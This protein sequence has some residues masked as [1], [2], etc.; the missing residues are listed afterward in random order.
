ME[1]KLALLFALIGVIIALSHLDDDR[2]TRVKRQ[3]TVWRRRKPS[4]VQ[5]KS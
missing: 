5:L 3:L 2:I 4:G 1:P